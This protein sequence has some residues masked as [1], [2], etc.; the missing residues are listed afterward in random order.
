MPKIEYIS[1]RFNESTLDLISIANTII[2]EY[3]AQGLNLTLRQLYYQFV[4]RDKIRNLQSEYKRLGGII[5]DAR[6]AGL[7]DWNSIVDRTRELEKNSH[8][9][10][11]QEIIDACADSFML[12]R[13]A[14]QGHRVEVWIEKDALVEVISKPCKALDVSFFSCRGYTSQSAMWQAAQRL[15]RYLNADQVPVI[16]HL[17]DHDPSGIDMSRDIR[18][19]LELFTGREI[20]VDR[21]A[22][23]MD[24]VRQYN[25]PPNPTKITDTRS[26][27]YIAEHGNECWELDALDP[28]TLIDLVMKET[29]KYMNADQMRQTVEQETEYIEQLRETARAL[30]DE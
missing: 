9:K 10:D 17:G 20:K 27:G 24:Q 2:Q 25:P 8:W 30:G 23:N 14:N 7:I 21:V 22:L 12:D 4:S 1:K 13:W 6:L 16:I 18:E 19:R 11:P 3:A 15:I 26:G 5:S 28:R 29:K